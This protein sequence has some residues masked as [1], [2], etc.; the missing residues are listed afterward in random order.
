MWSMFEHVIVQ[1]NVKTVQTLFR[2]YSE[3]ADFFQNFQTIFRMFRLCRFFSEFLAHKLVYSEFLDFV[4]DSTY[5][6]CYCLRVVKVC[7]QNIYSRV[8]LP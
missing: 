3:F 2:Q 5:Q 1:D 6:S 4:A 7:V 8:S